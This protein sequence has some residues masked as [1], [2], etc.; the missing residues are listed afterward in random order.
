MQRTPKV[1][2]INA[3]LNFVPA[4]FSLHF[5]TRGLILPPCGLGFNTPI[6]I[7]IQVYYVPIETALEIGFVEMSIKAMRPWL[8]IKSVFFTT[9]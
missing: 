5:Y 8:K 7:I 4:I 1:S 3:K 2:G 9:S 6:T